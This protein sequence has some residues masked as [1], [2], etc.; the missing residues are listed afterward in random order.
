MKRARGWMR[1]LAA[2]LS[3]A[4][5]LTGLAP[6][7][8]VEA[9]SNWKTFENRFG[10]CGFAN[11]QS[12]INSI[13]KKGYPGLY[14]KDLET[15]QSLKVPDGNYKGMRFWF[16]AP[17][18]TL[19]NNGTFKV[20]KIMQANVW[21]ERGIGN[22]FSVVDD[23]KFNV[24]AD[25]EVARLYVKKEG[26]KVNVI[27]AENATLKKFGAYEK[28]VQANITLSKGANLNAVN[29][30]SD[31][32]ELNVVV[33]EGS[34]TGTVKVNGDGVEANIVV[35]GTVKQILVAKPNTNVVLEGDAKEVVVKT[36]AEAQDTIITASVP[37]KVQADNNVELHLK[38]G[39]EG[40]TVTKT[41]EKVEVGVKNESKETVEIKTEGSTETEKVESGDSTVKEETG[42]GGS[43]DDKK[44]ETGDKEDGSGTTPTPNPSPAPNPGPAPDPDLSKTPL[45]G[46]T[47]SPAAV[48]V[49]TTLEAKA[50]PDGA[51]ADYTWYHG[52]DRADYIG[53]GKTYQ[54]KESDRGHKISVVAAGTGEYDG[55]KEVT[56]ATAV[57]NPISKVIIRGDGLTGDTTVI[58]TA[59]SVKLTAST[60][61]KNP[62]AAA[63][64]EFD[65]NSLTW[66]I[67][68][69][70]GIATLSA[71]SG[72][73]TEVKSLNDATG[74]AVVQ[75]SYNNNTAANFT[76]IINDGA[77]VELVTVIFNYNGQSKTVSVVSGGSLRE[78]QI[79]TDS[80]V[81]KDGVIFKGWAESA[82]E[83]NVDNISLSAVL[84]SKTLTA[85]VTYYA[86]YAEEL[87]VSIS[88]EGSGSTDGEVATGAVLK[89]SV[90]PAGATVTYQWMRDDSNIQDAT[91]ASY[92]V[93]DADA[94]KA[95]RVKVTGTGL[96]TGQVV[97]SDAITV[98]AAQEVEKLEVAIT[99][100]GAVVSGNVPTGTA[101]SA[102]V[103]PAGAK[104]SY[105]WYVSG[106]AVAAATGSNYTVRDE[107]AG[108]TIYVTV[109]G[110]EGAYSGKVASSAS[111]NVKAADSSGEEDPSEPGPQPV[112]LSSV[113]ITSG[114][115]ANA[116]TVSTVA[117]G[118]ELS[119]KIS[120][121][122]AGTI[123]TPDAIAYT[124][125]TKGAD[126]TNTPIENANA[127]TYKAV[128]ANL[129][130]QIFVTV[131]GDGINYTTE[132]GG[133]ITSSAVTIAAI[134]VSSSAVSADAIT[135][136]VVSG[137]A[138]T[139]DLVA[140]PSVV[141]A[142]AEWKLTSGA[143]V[144]AVTFGAA[145]ADSENAV[146][147]DNNV[148][149]ATGASVTLTCTG[150]AGN[151]MTLVV[152]YADYNCTV[153]Y[154]I[155]IIESTGG[156]D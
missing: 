86:I 7:T 64:E 39:S 154:T 112:T 151:T 115:A 72:S 60:E 21:N 53:T 65:A 146:A 131:S 78:D 58:T 68:N 18:S 31:K 2:V 67:I 16:N 81:K 84:Q 9:A 135:I 50:S 150:E 48:E 109:T 132:N 1:K 141:G 118:T 8:P 94:G 46:V 73:S 103:T 100:G 77:T 105:Q 108:G 26:V 120:L 56:T 61:A 117:V 144:T 76:V 11:N 80:A 27:V 102:A 57:P 19:T 6:G 91:G 140:T 129:G 33:P 10:T 43:T 38:K 136:E 82:N 14:V 20:I 98:Q 74:T 127:A 12:G 22:S 152:T 69:G 40:T 17:D 101:L 106:S 148:Y 34:K 142:E 133:V 66:S 147:P 139:L 55:T 49:G 51:D 92:T 63:T 123:T 116:P 130:E 119:A 83:T 114:S 87:K 35:D 104:V 107:D 113:Q 37:V 93:A 111:I 110:T 143:G 71:I 122:G 125:Y 149:T 13:L 45:A 3:L 5:V 54:I 47:I 134:A 52:D 90:V 124:W 88:V 85:G 95:I 153:E 42:D 96:Y 145:T 126:G 137:D 25:A 4:L 121:K 89:A 44:E 128:D 41:G 32:G 62:G 99:S 36:T 138:V 23:V 155:T 97:S 29:M 79:P 75:A 70:S 156:G 15:V 59:G 28:G 30:V 24:K